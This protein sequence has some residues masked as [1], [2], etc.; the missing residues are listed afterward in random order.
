MSYV[1]NVSNDRSKPEEFSIKDIEMFVDS[2]EQNWFKRA[3]VGKSLGLVDIH[4]S[5]ARL[6]DKDA[7]TRAFLKAEGGCHNATPSRED[8]KEQEQGA[9]ETHLKRHRATWI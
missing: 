7:K 6:A 4:R 3:H 9:Y 5:T 8:E 1:L 2:E